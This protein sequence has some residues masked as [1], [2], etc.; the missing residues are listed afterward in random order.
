MNTLKCPFCMTLLVV[1]GQERLETLDEHIFQCEPSLKDK[2][3]CP[4]QKCPTYRIICWNED[5]E[6][7][8]DGEGAERNENYKKM[9]KIEFID[10]NSGPFGS[11]QRKCNVEIYKKDENYS[12]KIGKF[13]FEI[14][15]CYQSDED[16]RIL[17]R[18]RRLDIWI[19][20]KDGGYVLYQSGIGM[21]KFRIK[22]FHK[23]RNFFP[24]KIAE[25]IDTTN[26][27]NKGDWWRVAG[28]WYA[29]VFTKLFPLEE[30]H[31][32][33]RSGS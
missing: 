28:C 11:F 6:M 12:F 26:W 32:V 21:L 33:Q 4:A 30:K 24:Q 10:K 8:T 18:R 27:K 14:V 5:G 7:Y 17:K 20:E 1:A 25:E 19:K 29:R 2:Y 15:F 23:Y 3:I 9:K 22:Q 31:E 13:K 16:G